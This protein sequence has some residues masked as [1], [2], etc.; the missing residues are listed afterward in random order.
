ML[1]KL[2]VLL[3]PVSPMII[4]GRFNCICFLVY[5]SVVKLQNGHSIL[6]E[7]K[8]LAQREKLS[9]G[10]STMRRYSFTMAL[11]VNFLARSG[12]EDVLPRS[13]IRTSLR[14]I[15]QVKNKKI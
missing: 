14:S 5:L 6:V 10:R 1:N 13:R 8:R 7:V 4:E 15:S 2:T 11:A 12:E 9:G 3:H